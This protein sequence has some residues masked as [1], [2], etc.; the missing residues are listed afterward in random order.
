MHVRSQIQHLAPVEA[1]QTIVAAARFDDA[2]E[3]KGH[4][5]AT[6]RGALFAE[7]GRELARIRYSTVFH[8]EERG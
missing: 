2:Y 8:I 1:G 5:Y 4:H 3:R 6:L 7:D